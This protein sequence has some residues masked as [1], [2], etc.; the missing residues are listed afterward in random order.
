MNH[1]PPGRQEAGEWSPWLPVSNLPSVPA[2]RLGTK[3]KKEP[4]FV[5]HPLWDKNLIDAMFATS[6][7]E[8]RAYLR[9]DSSLS[10]Q[11]R[12]R[13]QGTN[14]TDFHNHHRV[15]TSDFPISQLRKDQG[16]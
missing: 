14:R 5:V 11:R 7:A 1:W 15:G 13:A 4:T 6:S 10:T 2:R 3:E 12:V 8:G 16:K 9:P